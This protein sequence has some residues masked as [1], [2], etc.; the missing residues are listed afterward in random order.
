ML[1]V[2][3]AK[4]EESFHRWLQL[5]LAP[6]GVLVDVVDVKERNADRIPESAISQADCILV[7]SGDEA[8]QVMNSVPSSDVPILAI[9]DETS[10]KSRVKILEAGA[11]DC[12]SFPVAV[13]ELVARIRALVRRSNRSHGVRGFDGVLGDFQYSKE[14]RLVRREGMVILLTETE[15]GLLSCL[16]ASLGSIVSRSEMAMRLWGQDGDAEI[17]R[18]QVHVSNLRGKL[19]VNFTR[20][21]ILT[22][23]GRG[24]YLAT[25]EMVSGGV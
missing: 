2:A 21:L 24:Y 8:T 13:D 1:R 18:L 19:D 6:A 25:R 14:S 23:H 7:S 11:D 16:L 9:I 15:S 3:V 4:F 10:I 22:S 5:S 20:K 12:L 17:K